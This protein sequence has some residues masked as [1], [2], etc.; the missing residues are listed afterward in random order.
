MIDQGVDNY[1]DSDQFTEAERVALRYSAWMHKC[2]EKIDEAFYDELRKYYSTEE[3]VEMAAFNAFNIGYHTFFGTLDFY[4]MFTRT[5]GWSVRRNRAASMAIPPN[6]I[7][8]V[9][10]NGPP[11]QARKMPQTKPPNREE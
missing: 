1:E 2:P 7:C 6:P 8:R 10:T 9:P 4:P 3:I 5:D 11:K